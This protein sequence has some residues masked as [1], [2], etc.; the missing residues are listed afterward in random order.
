MTA[1]PYH[2][3]IVSHTHWDREWYQPFQVFRFRL[4]ELIDQLLDLLDSDPAYHSFL[5]D[6]QTIV[7]EDYLEMR[8][9]READLRRHIAAGRL[10]IGP[11]HILPD[12][13]LV[14]PEATVR[15]LLLG[16][17]VCA[18][19]GARLPIGYT[20]DP[21]GHISQLP[22]ILAGCGLE[23][24]ALQRGLSDE[25][26]ELWWEAPDGT[27]LLTIYFRE[28][29]GNLAWAP[30]TPEA[31]TRAV[32]RQI[33][34][35][36]PYA[37]TPNLL[38]LNGTDHM[39]PQPELPALIA[40]ANERLAGRAVLV[41]GTLPD[42]IARVKAHLGDSANL[43]VVQGELRSPKRTPV[44][45]GVLSARMW[46]KQRNHACE[47]A[48][49]RYA[50]PVSA[51]AWLCGGRDRRGELW[52]AWRYLIENHPH[53]S[54]CGC[55]VDQVHEEMRTRFAWSEQIAHEVTEAGLDHLARQ[56][57]AAQLP[58]RADYPEPD[59]PTLAAISA[60]SDYV[61][62]VYNPLAQPQTC[63]VEVTVSWPGS[64]M[65]W[66]LLDGQGR[67]VPY[68]AVDETESSSETMAIGPEEWQ[69]LLD[70]IEV[71]F[72][73]GRLINNVRVWLGEGHVRLEM[74]LPEYHT[75]RIGS[76][77]GLVRQLRSDPR[78]QSCQRFE[79]T[80]HLVGNQRL[81]F[82]A[83]DVFGLGYAC[84]RLTAV[85][86]AMASGTFAPR[87]ADAAQQPAIE[88]EWFRV[89]VAPDGTLTL[90]EKSTGRV[91]RG[92]NR[93][94]DGGDRGDEYNYCSPA[95]DVRVTTPLRPVRVEYVDD[96]PFGQCLVIRTVYALPADLTPDRDG[97][98]AQTVEMPVTTTVRVMPGVR[99][100]DVRTEL[101][102]QAMNHRLRVLFP[103]GCASDTAIVDGH[104]DRLK[105][106]VELPAD[107]T[108]W[109]EQPAPTAPQRAFTAVQEGG[110]GLLVATR[111]L[112]EYE[113]MQEGAQATIAVTLLRSV[114]WLSLDDL[115]CRPGHAGPKRATP[116]AQCLGP[117]AFEYSIIPFGGAFDLNQAAH[118]AYAFVAPLR[119][120]AV[121][122]THGSLPPALTLFTLYPPELVLTA[123]K[124]AEEGVGIIARF[125]NSSEEAVTGQLQFGIP[126]TQVRFANLL[127][128]P[129]GEAL[130]VDA[131]GR[132]ALRVPPKRIITLRLDVVPRD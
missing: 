64:G 60:K 48:L 63:P 52:R 30:T 125:Y 6:G 45:P 100:V 16:A 127:E 10:F 11:W 23:A 113:L 107:T 88:N 20:P 44:L 109:A 24:A 83:T 34:R 132:V 79:I 59:P 82:V 84:Y 56:I 13:F 104:F 57:D 27:R 49:E 1:T 26:T 73:K 106:R 91:L 31:F 8:P 119:S 36:A 19:F 69:A 3:T 97:R 98:S 65:G 22:Q 89:E 124:P 110:R 58:A 33:E 17:K 75:G 42:H 92:L 102:N 87:P 112:P 131:E 78:V 115:T 123:L 51:L 117:A 90:L 12:E 41:H 93:L 67:A 47:T 116:G 70:R 15:N 38:L 101:H 130:A 114:G 53:D 121:E 43:P 40:A 55:S 39:M 37:H 35:L 85:P 74:E 32:E 94:E 2:L 29:Y 122:T 76:F 118:L 46:I 103:T 21:F 111:G 5:L 72:Y 81:S 4:V 128:E 28:G 120:V 77:A 25:P 50:E 105:R 62:L 95:H 61:V 96:G 126:V 68:R 99:R 129:T 71:G 14:G 18:R 9:E 86:Q 80:A 108:G 54:I 7:L 66:Q